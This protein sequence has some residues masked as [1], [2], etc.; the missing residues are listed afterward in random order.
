MAH[1]TKN[2][3]YVQEE[4]KEFMVKLKVILKGY[5][6]MKGN[7]FG[8]C[9]V[10]VEHMLQDKA[11]DLIELIEGETSRRSLTYGIG[12][13]K[14]QITKLND[15]LRRMRKRSS[16]LALEAKINFKDN[17][18][19]SMENM[20]KDLQSQIHLVYTAFD[21]SGIAF[22]FPNMDPLLLENYH[23]RQSWG[24]LNED[25]SNVNGMNIPSHYIPSP[26]DED[27]DVCG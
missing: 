23:L 6:F 3:T 25:I 27:A 10:C 15:D 20:I 9:M 16:S 1:Q 13:T 22:A 8:L 14:S 26:Y 17:Q 24:Q 5:R 19:K 21:M 7:R 2:G 18:I 4:S 11:R 12:I